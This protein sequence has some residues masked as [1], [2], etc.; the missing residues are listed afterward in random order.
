[1][2]WIYPQGGKRMGNK[3]WAGLEFSQEWKQR[4]TIIMVEVTLK[5]GKT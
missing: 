1:M 3:K 2:V 4:K 5:Y